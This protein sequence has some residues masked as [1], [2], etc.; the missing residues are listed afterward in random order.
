MSHTG[1]GT[2]VRSNAIHGQ[3]LVLH[4]S[5]LLLSG[6]SLLGLLQTKGT[7]C[8]GGPARQPC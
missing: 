3:L 1:Y 7:L 4:V 2:I 8:R 5:A 6:F